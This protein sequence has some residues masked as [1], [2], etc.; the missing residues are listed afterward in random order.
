VAHLIKSESP[1]PHCGCRLHNAD[2]RQLADVFRLAKMREVRSILDWQEFSQN[3]GDYARLVQADVE[4][5]N[6]ISTAAATKTAKRI[7]KA[8]KTLTVTKSRK[9]PKPP[10]PRQLRKAKATGLAARVAQS[11]PPLDR[12]DPDPRWRQLAW[13]QTRQ[14]P[15]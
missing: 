13:E 9:A 8:Q 1:S 11:V 10:T 2:H 12:Y 5:D 14:R 6:L 7:R 15:R 4:S 3:H